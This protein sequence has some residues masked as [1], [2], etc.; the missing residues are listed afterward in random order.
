MAFRFKLDGQK[1]TGK[2]FGDEFDI[3]IAEG[4]DLR[5]SGTVH[6]HDDQLLQ[7]EH[8]ERSS[9]RGRSKAAEL[10]LVRERVAD[11]AG[12]SRRKR[13]GQASRPSN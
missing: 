10:E 13:S 9:T 12:Y 3:P 11:S 1:L 6:G 8:H 2:M 5:G 7:Q 4:S